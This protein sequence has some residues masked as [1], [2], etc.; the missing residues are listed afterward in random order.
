MVAKKLFQFTGDKVTGFT[1]LSNKT[2]LFAVHLRPPVN[3]MPCKL[4]P[5]GIFCNAES[6]VCQ[7][8]YAFALQLEP[9]YFSAICFSY[10]SIPFYSIF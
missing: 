2:Q 4:D 1:F 7:G 9:I 5:Q 10:V 6:W 3:S 8:F